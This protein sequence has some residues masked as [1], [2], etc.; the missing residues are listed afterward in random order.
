MHEE[1]K[2]IIVKDID[3][4]CCILNPKKYKKVLEKIDETQNQ[5]LLEP[6]EFE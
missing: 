5:F 4:C 2:D 3:D 6:A 1:E